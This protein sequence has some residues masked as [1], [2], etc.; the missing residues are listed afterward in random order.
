MKYVLESLSDQKTTIL[1]I[2]VNILFLEIKHQPCKFSTNEFTIA[3]SMKARAAAQWWGKKDLFS[4][5]VI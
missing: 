5:S 1:P 2:V 4:L 3:W